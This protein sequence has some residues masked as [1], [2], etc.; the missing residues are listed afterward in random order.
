M[1]PTHLLAR[2]ALAACGL[3]TLALPTPAPAAPGPTFDGAD[4]DRARIAVR[5]RPVVE[6][7]EQP[8]DIQPVP[9]Q[10]GT[11]VVLSKTGAAWWLSAGG[12]KGR[13][14]TVDPPTRSEQGLLGVAFPADFARSGRFVVHYTVRG[15]RGNR[16]RVEAWAVAPGAA[17]AKTKPRAERVILEVDQ[18]YRNHNAGQLAF[19]PDGMLYVGLGDGG[20]ANDPRGHG[21]NRGTL[22]GAML[23]LDVS[24]STDARPYAV[25]PD[26]PFA[27]PRAVDGVRPEIWAWGLRNPWRYA[28]APDGRLV[29]ADVGQNR[30]EE[31]TLVGAG[32]NHGWAAREAGHCFPSGERCT[33]GPYVDPIW[34]YPRGEGISI[35]GGPIYTGPGAALKN[36]YIFGDFGSGRMWALTLPP[37]GAK[38]AL[39]PESAVAALGRWPMQIST[40]GAGHDGT[41]Y[42]ADFGRGI[43]YRVAVTEE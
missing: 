10:P 12:E 31:V 5:L 2:A 20:A 21:Q 26:N 39:Q 38:K 42:V 43:I 9:G 28:F 36:R 30:Y 8:T 13:W 23:R 22:L 32:E 25:P 33:G 1:R 14:F 27:G 17:L 3:V 6:G 37:A 40:F 4:A 24:Q 34:Q 7:I 11:L 29:V 15:D 16:T 18:P 41:L 19:G 35:T